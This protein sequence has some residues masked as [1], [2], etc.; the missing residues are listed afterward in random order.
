[1]ATPKLRLARLVLG[2]AALHAMPMESWA[3]DAALLEVL[4]NN[5]LISEEQYQALVTAQE[6]A[7]QDVGKQKLPADDED[8]LD[9]LLSNNLISQ[10]QFAKLRVQTGIAKKTDPE[11]KAS[12]KE[13]IKFKSQDGAFQ[14]QVGVYM[15]ADSAIHSNDRTDF[16]NGT[17]LRRGRLSVGGTAFSTWDYKF[18]ADFA[19]STLGGSTNTVTV[20]DAFLRY[21]GFKPVT[22]TAGNFKVPFSLEAV[23]SAKYMTFMERGLPFAFLSTRRLG[24]MVGTNGDNWT[25]SAGW[26]GD[27]ITSQNAD[28]EGNQ[29]AGRATF[30]PIFGTDRVVHLGFSG[31]WIEPQHAAGGKLETARFRSKPEAN[32]ISDGLVESSFLTDANG[33]AFGLSSGRLVDTG[34]MG[35]DVSSYTLFGGELATVLG[36]FSLQGEYIR[37]DVNRSA[38]SD[39]GFDGF[40]A[41]GSWFITGESR[42]YRADKGVFD[43]LVPRK[44]FNLK[45]GDPGAWE[46]AVRYSNLDLNDEDIRGGELNDLTVGL[47]WYINQYVR[48]SANYVSVLDVSGG[49]HDNDEPSIYEMRMQFAY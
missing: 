40:Y 6:A 25:L 17:E 30:A 4:R 38:A 28:D 44:S 47:N 1:M 26:F 5:K 45:S 9:V 15:H 8:L 7:P 49:A 29:L 43:M 32:I 27:G 39:A 14:A 22:L 41:Y 19:G 18:E 16:S 33:N 20:T 11:S 10:E 42:A 3:A 21:T 13:G 36:P 35:G 48:L 46:I 12:L 37:A 2:L 24:G 31:G 34:S 23:G